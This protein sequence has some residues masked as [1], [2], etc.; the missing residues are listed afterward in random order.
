MIDDALWWFL[1]Y[2]LTS[3]LYTSFSFLEL[4]KLDAFLSV[5][6]PVYFF[7]LLPSL[8]TFKDGF[9]GLSL[10]KAMMDIRVL[11]WHT[12]QPI[13]FRRSF[14]RN[15][16]LLVPFVP[17]LV[18]FELRKGRRGGDLWAGTFVIWERYQDC[19]PFDLRGVLCTH[20]SYD[21]TGNTS[22]RCPECGAEIPLKTK[23]VHTT[24]Q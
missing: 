24:P 1:V 22:G 5:F 16:T 11:D 10:G 20:C 21:L 8:F 19:K 23:P 14:I 2:F 4:W 7:V 12:R 18:L 13:G 9:E 6:V 17:I 3:I 15:I